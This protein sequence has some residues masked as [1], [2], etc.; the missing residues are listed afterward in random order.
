MQLCLL[1]SRGPRPGTSV[2]QRRH[3]ATMGAAARCRRCHARG[4]CPGTANGGFSCSNMGKCHTLRVANCRSWT[5]GGSSYQIVAKSNPVVAAT[6]S[7]HHVAGAACDYLGCWL[8]PK[9]CKQAPHLAPFGGP[10]S[11][12][13]FGGGHHADRQRSV[14]A[15]ADKP[16]ASSNDTPQMRDQHIGV[17][18]DHEV[19][20]HT[21]ARCC[22]RPPERRTGGSRWRSVPNESF[23]ACRSD[24]RSS[25][26]VVRAR[27]SRRR[28]SSARETPSCAANLSRLAVCSSSR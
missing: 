16:I 3:D 21:W 23:I 6:I 11:A 19:A 5:S 25:P 18:K 24:A 1:M 7:A 22:S 13:E 9:R 14:L 15:G 10:H 17:D 2:G 8:Y 28:I 26:A 4:R 20:R 12:D 27:F